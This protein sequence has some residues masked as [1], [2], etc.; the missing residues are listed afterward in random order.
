MISVRQRLLSVLLIGLAIAFVILVAR[1]GE[2][3]VGTLSS[4]DFASLVYRVVLLVFL[5]APC[6]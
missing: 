1:H 2:G 3:Y 4:G 6:W 5:G